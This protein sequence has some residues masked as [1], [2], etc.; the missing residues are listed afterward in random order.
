MKYIDSEFVGVGERELRQNRSFAKDFINRRY[1]LCYY[2]DLYVTWPLESIMAKS[3]SR[4]TGL[5]LHSKLTLYINDNLAHRAGDII[6][7]DFPLS[8][9]VSL[10]F[11]DK[12]ISVYDSFQF[13]SREAREINF[14][15]GDKHGR[16]R[17]R[18]RRFLFLFSPRINDNR[19]HR[20]TFLLFLS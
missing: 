13:R 10:L 2:H 9:S 1:D 15:R 14:S 16:H 12:T 17:Q 20:S 11:C 19:V 5:Q 7:P 18:E 4:L 8:K 3:S 6:L